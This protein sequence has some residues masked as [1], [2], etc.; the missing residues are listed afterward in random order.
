MYVVFPHVHVRASVPFELLEILPTYFG[1]RRAR[2][3]EGVI[4]KDGR[5]E[6]IAGWPQL[7]G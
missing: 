1:R 3:A 2:R 6:T 4:P 7:L 5:R